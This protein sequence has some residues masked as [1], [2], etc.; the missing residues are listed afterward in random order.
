MKIKR[1]TVSDVS[2]RTLSWFGGR[3]VDWSYA[4][5]AY[6]LDGKKEQLQKYHFAYSFD[7]G[8]SSNDGVYVLLYKK[9]GTKA[10]LLKNGE[11]FRELDRSYYQ[12]E[13][14]EYPAAFFQDNKG[15]TCIAHC[16]EVYNRLEFEDAE[17]GEILTE[18]D[19][20]EL[21]DIFHSRLIVSPDGKHLLSRGWV[22]HPFDVIELFNIEECLSRPHLLDRGISPNCGNEVSTASFI[23]NENILIGSFDYGN[24]EE[25]ELF[26]AGH[27]AVWNFRKNELSAPVRPESKIG[28]L[29]AINLEYAWDFYGYPKI[30]SLKTGKTEYEARDINSGL[31]SSSI[32]HHLSEPLPLVSV[33]KGNRRAAFR[34]GS[35]V[36]VLECDMD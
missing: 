19:T 26:P 16:P 23:D 21:Q 20:R 7:S 14:Y 27:F 15:R 13:V 12:S 36:E 31:Q 10:L 17:T 9:L 11:E 18:S 33:E 24:E 5:T 8:I 25:E 22:W 1:Y 3:I 30:I 32:M 29:A 28:N 34:N 35:S 4:G 6:S 2:I